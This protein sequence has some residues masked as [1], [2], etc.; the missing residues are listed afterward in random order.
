MLL[1]FISFTCCWS[2]FLIAMNGPGF[3]FIPGALRAM[4]IWGHSS[5]S[6]PLELWRRHYFHW[7]CGGIRPNLFAISAK[8]ELGHEALATAAAT[9]WAEAQAPSILRTSLGSAVSILRPRT[10]LLTLSKVHCLIPPHTLLISEVIKLSL[11]GNILCFL[12]HLWGH[13]CPL[14][15]SQNLGL[16]FTVSVGKMHIDGNCEGAKVSPQFLRVSPQYPAIREVSIPKGEENPDIRE[17][18]AGRINSLLSLV[19]HQLTSPSLA[20]RQFV[21]KRDRVSQLRTR[22]PYTKKSYLRLFQIAIVA[23]NI[24]TSLNWPQDSWIHYGQEISKNFQYSL[25]CEERSHLMF[26]YIIDTVEFD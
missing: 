20:A 15:I 19:R 12:N 26:Q 2:N 9:G 14:W 7:T 11:I 8:A 1:F 18:T 3:P 10:Q 5:Y 21:F 13:F 16:V 17:V 23:V 22:L 25:L 4:P 24:L 6:C